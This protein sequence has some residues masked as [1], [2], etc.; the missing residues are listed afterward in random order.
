MHDRQGS[1]SRHEYPGN[2][3]GHDAERR[4]SSSAILRSDKDQQ[5]TKDDH[6]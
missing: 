5:E 3:I 6:N 2:I 1:A 4:L